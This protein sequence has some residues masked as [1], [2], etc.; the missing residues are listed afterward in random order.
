MHRQRLIIIGAVILSLAIVIAWLL[1]S[2]RITLF[3]NKDTQSSQSPTIPEK[4]AEDQL[5]CVDAFPNSIKIG[6]KIM[7]AGYEDRL[8]EEKAVFIQS[9]IGGV[10]IMNEISTASLQDF[11]NGFLFAPTVATDQE[12]G[13]VQRYTAEGSFLGASDIASYSTLARAYNLYLSDAQYLKSIGITT[14]FAPVVD[15]ASVEPNPLPGRM[16]SSDPSVVA[17]YASQAIKAA[18]TSGISPVVKH[19]PGLGSATGNTDFM[20]ATTDS[21]S[22]LLTRDLLPYQQLATYK[23][24]V[25]V[26]NAITPGLT[27]GQPAIWSPTA[28]SLLRSYGYQGSVIYSDSLTAQAVPGTLEDAVIK[29]WQAGI[30]VALIVQTH[31]QTPELAS[32]FQTIITR[33]TTAL[34]SGELDSKEFSQSVLRILQRKGINPCAIPH[35]F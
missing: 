6:Q 24:D 20:T 1:M 9:N 32:D 10:I 34:Q 29:S 15:V 25:M 22:V 5:A 3:L 23:P 17:N 4:P 31:D 7:A 2:G 18:Q 19:F 8:S 33:A 11:K 30:D 14:N 27:D 21:F 13:T 28:V 35:N 12:G 16:Y 26:S